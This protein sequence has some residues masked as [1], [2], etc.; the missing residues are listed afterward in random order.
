M[1]EWRGRANPLRRGHSHDGYQLDNGPRDSSRPYQGN[2][3]PRQRDY[4]REYYPR[5]HSRPHEGDG[6][7]YQGDYR[8][9]YH[10]R[11]F[12][13]PHERDGRCQSEYRRNY[14]ARM[15]SRHCEE[16]RDCCQ[17]RYYPRDNRDYYQ[18]PDPGRG[19][20][21]NRDLDL[22]LDLV[23]RRQSTPSSRQR[24]MIG[25]SP[26]RSHGG[27]RD[28]A[29][30]RRRAT[31]KPEPSRLAIMKRR[32]QHVGAQLTSE[33]E[34]SKNFSFLFAKDLELAARTVTDLDWNLLMRSAMG[35]VKRTPEEIA[36]FE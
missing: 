29:L 5:H 11:R 18:G 34:E 30:P 14:Y 2:I 17:H 4:D 16:G 33:W 10:T 9:D 7:R 19:R 26:S 27:S 3:S 24:T 23:P 15:P 21:G 6:G 35:V 8:H 25:L 1:E 32:G 12:R 31:T 13:R 36:E 20:S 22:D 28:L